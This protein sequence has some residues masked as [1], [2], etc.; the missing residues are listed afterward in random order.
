MEETITLKKNKSRVIKEFKNPIFQIYLKE[1]NILGV[2]ATH[3][4]EYDTEEVEQIVSNIK[5]L[6]GNKKYLLL[7]KTG[8][9]ATITFNA[10]KVLARPD[11]LSYAHA[12]AYVISTL[13]QR[14]MA[15]FFL[16][17]FK[18]TIPVKFF[19]DAVDAEVWLLKN[20]RHLCRD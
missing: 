4:M 7:V 20:F 13:P 6:S 9:L 18:P 19:K 14:F 17:Y 11:A 5:Y 10:L 2:E 3:D 16:R 1:T 15:N 12:K 8:S